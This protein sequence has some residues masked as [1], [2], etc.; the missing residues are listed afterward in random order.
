MQQTETIQPEDFVVARWVNA[1]PS[2]WVFFDGS[3]TVV[4]DKA[5]VPTLVPGGAFFLD[6]ARSYSNPEQAQAQAQRLNKLAA[7]ADESWVA[8]AAR[9]VIAGLNGFT[10]LVA[11]PQARG[12]TFSR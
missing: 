12:R 2:A 11:E 4:E 5:G 9:R 7:G 6:E 8:I 1:A 3:E 10:P